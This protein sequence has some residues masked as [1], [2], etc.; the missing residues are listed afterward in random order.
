MKKKVI[1]FG[2]TSGIGNEIFKLFEKDPQSIV[3][4]YPVL[5]IEKKITCRQIFQIQKKLYL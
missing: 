2:A 3:I 4:Q 5:K 1:V